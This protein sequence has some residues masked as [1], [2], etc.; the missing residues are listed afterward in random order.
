MREK[1]ILITGSEGFIATNLIFKLSKIKE[2][3]LIGIDSG[4][5]KSSNKNFTNN[6]INHNLVDISSSSCL[7]LIEGSDL[8]VHLAARGSVVESLENPLENFNA[9]VYSTL[10]LLEAM[11]KTGV[12]NIVFSSTGGALMGNTPP[13]VNETSL[14][15]PISPYGSSK[16]CCEGYLSSYA[17]S[18]LINSISLR[19][20]NVYG[21]FS[22]H[23]KGVINKW[24]RSAIKDEEIE[25]FGNGKSTRDYIHVDDICDGIISSMKRLLNIKEPIC[26]KYHL[27]NNQ[28]ISLIELLD[29]I[30]IC[31]KKKLSR[32]FKDNR[33]GEVIRNSS[34]FQLAKKILNFQPKKKFDKEIPLLYDWISL[35]EF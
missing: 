30:E 10:I 9:N 22:A 31:S 24:I 32:N 1:K 12:R 29:I 4:I 25:I 16:L 3:N 13:P 8:I 35:N 19:F 14:P 11:R 26:E 7:D 33:I 5:A 23:K 18:F 21:K 28:E 15:A 6:L 17:S 34:E 20:G 2:F 27:A